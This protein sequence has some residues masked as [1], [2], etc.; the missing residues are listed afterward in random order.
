MVLELEA[1][2]MQLYPCIKDAD[3]AVASPFLQVVAAASDAMSNSAPGL[4][5]SA[6]IVI[7][8]A[9]ED[10][11][12]REDGN[13]GGIR[14]PVDQT[15]NGYRARP[16]GLRDTLNVGCLRRVG[17]SEIV[18]VSGPFRCV[19]A[20]DFCAIGTA[21]RIRRAPLWWRTLRPN[22]NETTLLDTHHRLAIREMARPN[23]CTAD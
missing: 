2:R 4:G 6:T 18:R 10:R 22:S 13:H 11:R 21:P 12:R 7:D 9:I 19:R 23:P 15:G 14:G 5:G 1:V 20:S 8:G 3:R 16:E 17:E